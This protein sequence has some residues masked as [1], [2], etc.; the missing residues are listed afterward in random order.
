V[1]RV[2]SP[3]AATAAGAGSSPA[4]PWHRAN[5]NV[6]SVTDTDVQPE[7]ADEQSAAEGVGRPSLLEWQTRL[8]ASVG[9]RA[10]ALKNRVK[11]MGY[12]FQGNVAQYKSL[13]ASLQNPAVSLPIM[14]VRN[15]DAHDD[16]LSEAESLLH[17]VLTAMSTRV[18]QQRRFMEKYFQGDSV[19]MKEYGERIAFAVS[20][21]PAFLKGLRNYITHTQLPVAQSRQ[22]LGRESFSVTFILPSKPLLIWDGWNSSIRAWIVGQGEAVAIVDVV[23]V[24]ARL[25]GEFDKWLFDRIGLKYTPE[26]DAF[27]REQEEYTREF[28]RV[29]GA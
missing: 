7:P 1:R 2:V 3:E 13:V 23:D 21:E 6:A 12:I 20:P 26:I 28:D 17:N 14:D 4:Y 25:A 11:R 22:T 5:G 24:Y 16:L 15:P 29:F 27:L 19:L 9:F 10:I 8:Q 18:D